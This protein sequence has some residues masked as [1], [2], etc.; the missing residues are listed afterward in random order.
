MRYLSSHGVLQMTYW[1]PA[2]AQSTSSVLII[3]LSW[4]EWTFLKELATHQFLRWI[5]KPAQIIHL[6]VWL[7]PQR[8]G[9]ELLKHLYVF[10]WAYSIIFNNCDFFPSSP[11]L[12]ALH[13]SRNPQFHL[14]YR[15]NTKF[16]GGLADVT[17]MYMSGRTVNC[18]CTDKQQFYWHSCRT[19]CLS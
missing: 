12:L 14:F 18:W 11:F 3:V 6:F 15:A 7:S 1:A 4:M 10:S 9:K 2:G 17:H 13:F 8:E 16:N 19:S 5:W